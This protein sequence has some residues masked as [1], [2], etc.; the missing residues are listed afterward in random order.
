[1]TGRAEAMGG[2]G[3]ARIGKLF[4]MTFSVAG[5]GVATLWMP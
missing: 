4:A 1:M 5:V 3:V 2:G